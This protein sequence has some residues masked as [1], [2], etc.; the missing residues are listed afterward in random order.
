[1]SSVSLIR[2]GLRTGAVIV[3]AAL[4]TMSPCSSDPCDMTIPRV[5]VFGGALTPKGWLPRRLS[6]G[7]VRER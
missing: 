6:C 1:M 5:Q 7:Q 2:N 4:G 3:F